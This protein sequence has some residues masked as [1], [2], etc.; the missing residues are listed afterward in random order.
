MFRKDDGMMSKVGELIVRVRG[1]APTYY[2]DVP[3]DE[4]DWKDYLA[5]FAPKLADML[6]RAMIAVDRFAV[7]GAAD[8]IAARDQIEAMAEGG[9]S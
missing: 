2:P 6:E 3:P 8:A 4:E 1:V 5:Y 9:E 7:L